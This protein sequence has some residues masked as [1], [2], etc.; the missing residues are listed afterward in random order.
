MPTAT[1]DSSESPS[2]IEVFGL[3]EGEDLGAPGSTVAEPA[4]SA[5]VS[6]DRASDVSKKQPRELV[7]F[8]GVNAPIPEG[9]DPQKWEDRRRANQPPDWQ[10]HRSW[11]EFD[12]G[13][14]GDAVS[15][16]VSQS[17]SVAVVGRDGAAVASYG[18]DYRE[19]HVASPSWGHV[20]APDAAF[21]THFSEAGRRPAEFACGRRRASR[22]DTQEAQPTEVSRSWPDVSRS[23]PGTSSLEGFV[24]QQ[25]REERRGGVAAAAYAEGGRNGSENGGVVREEGGN[26]EEDDMDLG[27]DDFPP[28]YA[29]EQQRRGG[30]AFAYQHGSGE[31]LTDQKL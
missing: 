21:A 14:S 4:P 31:N 13:G 16:H 27:A 3:D 26:A 1:E 8:P 30:P 20:A 29:N 11:S 15:E 19:A 25:R 28:G 23:W 18:W 24:E 9:A 17:T 6:T 12:R 2:G 22:W 5:D 10:V 7:V